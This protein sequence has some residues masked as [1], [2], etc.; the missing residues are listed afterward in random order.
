MSKILEQQKRKKYLYL[1]LLVNLGL[2]FSFK[3]L[4]FFTD[5]LNT[6][7]TAINTDYKVP[8]IKLLLPVGISFYTFQTLS[9]TIDVYRGVT[10][11][12]RHFGRF[13]L[14]VS[15]WPQLVAGPIERSNR[16]L[17]QLKLNTNFDSQRIIHGLVQMAYGFFKKIVVADRLAVYVNVVFADV[18]NFSTIPLIIAAV[19]FSFQIYADFSG[20]SDIAIG[21]SRIMGVELM[22]NFRRPYL[23]RSISEFW[24]RWHI[25]LSS[26]FRDY[27]YI[28]LG[29]NRTLKWRWYYNLFITFLVS[30]LW[31]GANWT[32]V[33]WGALHGFYLIA[34]IWLDSLKKKLKTIFT[35][36][37]K[38][39]Y[40]KIQQQLITYILVV[41]GWIFFRAES[42]TSAGLYL[43]K[44]AS[45]DFTFHLAQW[46]A[47]Q[48]PFNLLLS[49]VAIGLLLLSYTLPYNLK[50][51][52]NKSFIVG[53]TV[54]V[55]LLGK[56]GEGEFIYFQF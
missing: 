34:A 31:H 20:Y 41:L 6:A 46:C 45:M 23:S 35:W 26:W 54:L 30:G 13:A 4:Y 17:P 7:F 3:Y 27:V 50:L 38:S 43:K 10:Q 28:P 9:Y 48:G 12:E 21:A 22:D 37:E 49:F 18:E 5:S 47:Y 39:W 24:K 55:L 44:I 25:S 32:F 2:L 14:Y 11:A 52:H 42:I 36:K 53:V 16:L 56:G 1:S 29:G 8:L 15:Y 19:F 40:D 33:V 51:R